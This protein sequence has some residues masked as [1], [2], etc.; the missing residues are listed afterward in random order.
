MYLGRKNPLYYLIFPI[1]LVSGPGVFIDERTVLFGKDIFTQSKNIYKDVIML[2]LGTVTLYLKPRARMG[3]R[4]TK[5]MQI[6][7]IYLLILIVYTWAKDGW[8]YEAINVIRL[9]IYM[10]LGF[11]FLYAIL[12]TAH[13][14][15]FVKFFN[16]LFYATGVLS[17]LYVLNSSKI[18]PLYNTAGLFREVQEGNETFF[19][20]FNTIP[21]FG[22]LLFVLGFSETLMKSN[23][24]NKKGIY[25]VLVTYPF[26][27]LFSFT[28]SLLLV[29]ILQLCIITFV[30]ALKHPQKVFSNSLLYIVLGGFASFLVIQAIF[31]TQVSYFSERLNNA[32]REGLNEGNVAI[33]IA[34][35]LTAADI[36]TRNNSFL[37]GEGLNKKNDDR[38][39]VIGAWAADSTIPFWLIYTGI[40]GVLL[41]YYLSFY[42]MIYAYKQFSR[43]LNSVSLSLFTLTAFAAFASLIMGGYRWGDPFIFFN[44]AL[45]VYFDGYTYKIS[46]KK[47]KKHIY[48]RPSASQ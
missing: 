12:S 32:K 48:K 25:L 44:L 7:G 20:D 34:Y 19:R 9:F 42:F 10:V 47:L 4:E 5:P 45:L 6:L 31:Q 24:F 37:L 40:I 30:I 13:F 18:L 2:Y 39:N 21:Y 26:V 35:H 46:A 14:R 1:A 3:V 36:V 29:T 38:M 15:Q 33:R 16:S 22:N 8:N 17:V 28:R 41:F 23:I 43:T 27:L 11:Y